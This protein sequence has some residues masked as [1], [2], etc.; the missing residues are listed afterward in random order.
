MPFSTY[1]RS[2]FREDVGARALTELQSS[3]SHTGYSVLRN[4]A[5]FDSHS[6]KWCL[7]GLLANDLLRYD[8]KIILRGFLQDEVAWNEICDVLNMKFADMKNWQ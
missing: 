4:Q 6:I 5:P 3:T 2:L 1:L 7:K 8:K